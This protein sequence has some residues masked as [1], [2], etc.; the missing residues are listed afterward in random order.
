MSKSNGSMR[1]RQHESVAAK[2]NLVR[3]DVPH[4]SSSVGVLRSAISNLEIEG[5]PGM[6]CCFHYRAELMSPATCSFELR[7]FQE[8][9]PMFVGM[10]SRYAGQLTVGLNNQ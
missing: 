4:D 10:S 8:V 9:F 1:V 3:E 6:F 7:R 5:E 2:P